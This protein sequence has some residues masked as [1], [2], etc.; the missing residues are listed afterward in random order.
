ARPGWVR[1]MEAGLAALAVAACVMWVRVFLADVHHNIAIAYSKQG[2]W[3]EALSNYNAVI[4]F[5]S[6]YG[7][8]H[9]FKGNVYNDRWD[10]DE[11][12]FLKAT[13]DPDSDPPG[14]RPRTDADRA[15]EKYLDVKRL[16]PNY[17][18]THFQVANVYKKLAQQYEREERK[19]DSVEMWRTSIEHYRRAIRLDPVFPR[20]YFEMAWAYVNLGQWTDAEAAFVAAL[21]KKPDYAEAYVNLGNVYYMQKKYRQAEWAYTRAGEVEPGFA[22]AHRNLAVLYLKTGRA[23]QSL[24]AWTKV[25]QITPNDQQAKEMVTG[26]LQ[27][28]VPKMGGQ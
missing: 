5:N 15:L 14:G 1:P 17:V 9:Y 20:N 12:G 26:L 3:P 19:A 7:M 22:N 24:A 27:G 4:R 23:S 16:M 2:A 13:Y 18:Q 8:T 25:L 10:A 11:R 28:R 21:K 6:T